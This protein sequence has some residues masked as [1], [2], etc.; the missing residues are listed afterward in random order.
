MSARMFSEAVESYNNL[1]SQY[2]VHKKDAD[3][4]EDENARLKKTV[5][6]LEA[7]LSAREKELKDAQFKGEYYED[8]STSMKL[9][10]TV[11]VRA[12]MTKKYSKGKAL[13]WDPVT[14][15]SA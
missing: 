4:K 9:F 11:K 13:S 5:E 2:N 8:K 15:S 12:E 6:D 14:A 1:S 10:T 3:V 7:L